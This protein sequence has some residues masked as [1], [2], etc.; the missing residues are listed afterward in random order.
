MTNLN[1]IKRNM[2]TVAYIGVAPRPDFAVAGV[3]IISE[4]GAH[5]TVSAVVD[6]TVRAQWFG[7]YN[8]TDEAFADFTEWVIDYIKQ[9]EEEA[10]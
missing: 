7:D 10:A 8:T 2:G 9:E 4:G 5:M 6:T 3:V 1:I